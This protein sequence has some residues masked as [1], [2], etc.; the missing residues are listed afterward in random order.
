METHREAFQAIINHEFATGWYLGPF[1]A[2]QVVGLLGPFQTSPLSL[3]PKST[4]GKFRL[5]QNLSFPHLARSPGLPKSLAHMRTSINAAID[6]DAFPCT[7]GT[8]HTVALVVTRLPEGSQI[9]ARDVAEVYRTVPLAPSQWPGTVVRL[10]PGDSF[11]INT[12]NCFGL[13]SAS[14]V[15]GRLAD[16]LCNIFRASGIGPVSKWVDDFVFFRLLALALP[17]YNTKRA[18]WAAQIRRLGGHQL[19]RAR[20]WFQGNPLLVGRASEFDKDCSAVLVDHSCASPRSEADT[21]FT[22]ADTDISAIS[23]V[24]QVPW[25]RDKGTLFA[26]RATYM[27]FYWDLLSYRVGIPVSKREKYCAA[28]QDFTKHRTHNLDQVQGLYSKLLHC[29]HILPHGRAYLT[30]L[31]RTMALLN[32]NPFCPVHPACGVAGDLAWCLQQLQHP[33]IKRSLLE[34]TSV[35]DADAFSD[36]S[37]GI[38]IGIILSERW[39]MWYLR[40]GWHAE[41]RDITWAEVVGFE[42]LVRALLLSLSPGSHILVYGNNEGIVG[43]WQ[44]FRSCS[45]QVNLDF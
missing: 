18:L 13:A 17:P 7:W 4:P 21:V 8:F 16:A 33:C 41:G 45:H 11:A 38:G 27:G 22:Y 28:I 9:A 10:S 5:I 2:S 43:A 12:C 20:I 42:L 25:A 1:S 24:L 39:I 40:D 29:A 30:G 31:E 37:S 36:V 14:G 26:Y 34:I 32:S 3:V 44:H 23:D 35:V 19:D 6:S 15:W